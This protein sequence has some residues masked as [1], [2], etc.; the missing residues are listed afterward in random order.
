MAAQILVKRKWCACFDGFFG[1][2]NMGVGMHMAEG[3]KAK[4]GEEEI[5]QHDGDYSMCFFQSVW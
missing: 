5:F 1:S 4:G 3:G 2:K